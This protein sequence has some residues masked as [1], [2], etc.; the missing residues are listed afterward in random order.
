MFDSW[1]ESFFL[2]AWVFVQLLSEAP[3]LSFGRVSGSMSLLSFCN[4]LSQLV[5][6][7]MYLALANGLRRHI[8]ILH[9]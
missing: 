5:W 2:S 4:N 6:K 7:W 8:F 1:G 3:I 9:P